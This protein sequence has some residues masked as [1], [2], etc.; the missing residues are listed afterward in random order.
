MQ[1]FSWIRIE[2]QIWYT[3]SH[4][5]DTGMSEVGIFCYLDMSGKLRI[6]TLAPRFFPE[7]SYT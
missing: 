3:A 2:N 7:G 5:T 1:M 6:C 4:F